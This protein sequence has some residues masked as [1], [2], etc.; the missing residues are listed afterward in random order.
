MWTRIVR[1]AG[2]YAAERLIERTERIR[3]GDFEACES[4]AYINDNIDKAAE[5]M[6][7]VL[8]SLGYAKL[9]D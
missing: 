4:T 5:I 1:E 3:S 9:A 8:G 6:E 2:Q 7:G